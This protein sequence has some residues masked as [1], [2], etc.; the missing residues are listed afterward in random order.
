VKDLA[1]GV[2][3]FALST[4]HCAA[5]HYH[6][7]MGVGL[8]FIDSLHGMQDKHTKHQLQCWVYFNQELD[9]VA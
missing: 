6:S 2:V 7:L 3:H 8:A 4:Q 9:C 5:A 1:C